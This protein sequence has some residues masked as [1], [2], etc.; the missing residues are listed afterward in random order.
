MLQNS[1]LKRQGNWG[2]VFTY[3]LLKI[4][5]REPGWEA[6]IDFV[7]LHPCFQKNKVLRH[8]NTDSWQWEVIG[9]TLKDLREMPSTRE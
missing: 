2:T 4:I 9:H 7:I 6:Y 3:Q 5:I 8:R 1:P